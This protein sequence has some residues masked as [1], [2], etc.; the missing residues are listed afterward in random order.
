MKTE[1]LPHLDV[2]GVF[3]EAGDEVLT[4]HLCLLQQRTICT[5]KERAQ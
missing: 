1:V 3:G 4:P 5:K 2:V